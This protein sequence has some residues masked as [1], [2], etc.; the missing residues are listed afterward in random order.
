M[1]IAEIGVYYFIAVFVS[2]QK[3]ITQ[4]YVGLSDFDNFEKPQNFDK[5][6]RRLTFLSK[7][8]KAYI[9]IAIIYFCLSPFISKRFCEKQNQDREFKEIC[10]LLATTWMPFNIDVFPTKQFF[11]LW[12]SYTI[13]FTMKGAALISFAMMETIE[14]LV[15]RIK[16]LK[17]MLNEAVN[18]EDATTRQQRFAKCIEY[19]INIFEYSSRSAIYCDYLLCFSIGKTIDKYYT[20]CLFIHVLLTGALFGCI[21]YRFMEVNPKDRSKRFHFFL[22]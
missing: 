1:M 9:D 16:H 14:H 12:Q 18:T 6:N 11:F 7:M 19:H 8:Y 13:V 15:V 5:E 3:Q 10:G 20:R 21:G 22:F 4:I 17:L 2:H